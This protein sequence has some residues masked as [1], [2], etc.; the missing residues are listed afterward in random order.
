[1]TWGVEAIPGQLAERFRFSNPQNRA[2]SAPVPEFPA[3][4]HLPPPRPGLDWTLLAAHRDAHRGA[5]FYLDC[6]EYAHALWGRG[7]AARAM[8]CLDRA[9]GAELQGGEP[10]L[11]AWP[12]PY[13]A[14]TW[15]L[16]H[17]PE[18]VFVGNSRVHFQHYAGRMNEPRREQRRWRAW[19][20]WALARQV[21]PEL[22]GD[23]R[24][25][26]EEPELPRIERELRT[27]GF[28]GEPEL[29]RAV[30]A[31]G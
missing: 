18:G 5:D 10:V 31:A 9:F 23:P 14:V 25:A 22:P 28:A 20:C 12:M 3:C 29:W 15:L 13:A 19:A 6:L 21:R 17:T 11:A 8:L 26:V 4:P 2:E 24:H 27:H 30:L 1:M 16:R 7:L